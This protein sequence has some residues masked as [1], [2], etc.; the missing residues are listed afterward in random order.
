MTPNASAVR[1][2]TLRGWPATPVRS[3]LPMKSQ[4]VGAARVLGEALRR[5]VELAGARVEVDVLEDRPEAA[6]R[7]EDVRL[8]HRGEAD[9][10]G[11]AAALEVEDAAV[12]PAVLVVADQAAP[13]VG[14]E[15]RLARPRQAEEDHRV[16][17]LA[18]VDRG[19]HREHALV[20]QQVVHH[21]ER[22][23]LDLAGVFGAD[24]DDLHPLE[25]DEDGRLGAGPLGR[26]VGLE[27][28]DADDREV[29]VAG[30][31]TG[32]RRAEQVAREEAGPGRLRVDAQRPAMG[33]SGSDRGVLDVQVAVREVGHESRP[34]PVVVGLADRPVDLAP[35]DVVAGRGLVDDELVERR[36]AGVA[37]GPDD[38]GPVG[39]DDA[40]AAP[41][42][43]L[44]QLGGGL[45]DAQGAARGEPEGG[46]GCG[47]RRWTPVTHGRSSRSTG[48]A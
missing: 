1:K 26:R 10:L 34:K 25:V 28:R 20:G 33:G 35:P 8:V 24:D 19:V 45:V 12:A 41:D 7:L 4:R 14:R 18:D 39:R 48:R 17:R 9:G 46:R 23:L 40:L 38:Q 42:G 27:R 36:P 16:S 29:G 21:G 3:A 47:H 43:V 15:R 37:A 5:E 31:V 32:Q 13:R 6:R 44:V 30:L 2:T 11:V 22:R